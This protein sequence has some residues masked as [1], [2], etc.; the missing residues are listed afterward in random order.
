M[1]CVWLALL[2]LGI[3]CRSPELDDEASYPPD[4]DFLRAEQTLGFGWRHFLRPAVGGLHVWRVTP[5]ISEDSRLMAMAQIEGMADDIQDPGLDDSAMRGLAFAIAERN[6]EAL[7]VFD[8][9]T[10]RWP[11]CVEFWIMGAITLMEEGRWAEAEARLAAASRRA[12][13]LTEIRLLQGVTCYY[14]GRANYGAAIFRQVAESR[15][16]WSPAWTGLAAAL[17]FGGQSME[18]AIRAAKR[19]RE[20][21]PDDPD[22]W[23]A[24]SWVYRRWNENKGSESSAREAIAKFDGSHM[25]WRELSA[26]LAAQGRFE[27]ADTAFAKAMQRPPVCPETLLSRAW[28]L[29]SLQGKWAESAQVCRSLTKD[30]PQFAWGWEKLALACDKLKRWGEAA[31]AYRQALRVESRDNMRPYNYAGLTRALSRADRHEEAEAAYR[32]WI[33]LEPVN[34]TPW[35]GLAKSLVAQAEWKEAES[36]VRRVLWLS[37]GNP[38]AKKERYG[39]W[40]TLGK[41]CVRQ[42]RNDEARAAFREALLISPKN[43]E[44]RKALE[45]TGADPDPSASQDR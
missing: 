15:P 29:G 20:L 19:A 36:A 25:A 4:P 3:A 43:E 10:R 6:E 24:L 40:Y 30:W 45:E 14:T 12:P 22:A 18:Y 39:A 37:A 38:F 42:N 16:D 26:A 5:N 2:L 28:Y 13:A 1:W 41:I 8:T 34:L 27:E 21:A 23:T 11:H 7:S 31:E 32:D 44:A 17:T 33:R 35:M 9:A